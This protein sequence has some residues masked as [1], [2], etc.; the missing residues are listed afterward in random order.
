MASLFA[1]SRAAQWK[2]IDAL[3]EKEQSATATPLVEAIYREARQQ[4]DTPDYVRALLYRLGLLGS[5][6]PEAE[7]QGIALLENDLA[8]ADFPA[9]P[10]LHSLLG[11][12]YTTYLRRYRYRVYQRTAGATP[13]A[14][15][16]GSTL[17]TWG[18]SELGA[19][20]VA[21][22]RQS[23]ADEPARQL[24][25]S[26][27]E[28]GALA[29]AGDK[30]GQILR[31]SLYD[32]LAWRAIQGL[33]NQ[34]L[35]LTQPE[36]Q[37]EFTDPQLFGSAAEFA[38][39]P[40]LAAPD[41][42]LNG[43]LHALQLLQQLTAQRLA[44]TPPQPT[45]L[46]AVDLQRLDYLADLTEG[47]ALADE[48]G[49]ALAR[50]ADLYQTL[51]ISAEFRARRATW[52]HEAGDAVA[53]V[54][55]ARATEAQFPQSRGAQQARQLRLEIEQPE[56][57][58]T[59]ADTV[60]PGQPW[61]LDL[62]LR[63]ITELHAWVYPLELNEWRKLG[64]LYGDERLKFQAKV[65]RRPVAASWA[66]PL[67][68]APLDYQERSVVVAGAALPVGYYL[69]L[70]SN[71]AA[72]PLQE[73]AGLA[74][75]FGPLAVSE[76][77]AVNRSTPA[78]LASWEVLVL[79]RQSGAPLA[80]VQVQAHYKWYDYETSQY[81][82]RQSEVLTTAASGEVLLPPAAEAE[83]L[84]RVHLWRGPDTLL[85]TRLGYYYPPHRPGP[86]EVQ[87]TVLL[88]TDRAIYRP[89]QTLYFKGVLSES[90]ADEA[91]VLPG[92]PVSVRLLDVN[93]QTALTL[94]FTTSSFG[95]FH[96]S[97]VLPTGLLNGQMTLQTDHGSVGFAVEDYKRPT[98]EVTLEPV[99]GQP[100]LGEAVTVSGQARAYAGQPT[101]GATVSYRVTRQALWGGW[102]PWGPRGSS[103]SQQ[104]AHGTTT[105]DAEGRFAITFTPPPAAA[106][107]APRGYQFSLV[108]DVTEAAGETRT[109]TR[110]LFIGANPLSVSLDGPAL[111]DKQHPEEFTLLG[112]NATGE[113]LPAT[114]TVQV[115]ARHY[116]PNPPGVP[117][118]VPKTDDNEAEPELMQTLAFDTQAQP[119]FDLT[120]A[121]A[122][123]PTGRYQLRAVADG[124]DLA[125]DTHDFTLYDSEAT[126]VPYATPD[127][128]LPLARQVAPGEPMALLLGSSEAG[129]NILLEVERG[130]E[131]LRREWLTLAAGEQR[132][133]M[134][135]SGPVRGRGALHVHTTQV[136]DNHLYRHDTTVQ[137]V[138]PP[139]PLVLSLSTFR[140]RLQPGEREIWRLTIRRADGQPAEAELLATLYD[141]SLD[142]FR[143]HGFGAF[144]VAGSYYPA[145][146]EWRGEFGELSSEA[147]FALDYPEVPGVEYPTLT[148][149]LDR[150]SWAT[151]GY[152]IGG[153]TG[154]AMRK[155]AGVQH[156]EIG[157]VHDG[158]ATM[159]WMESA[160]PGG[161]P[162]P[163]AAPAPARERERG[164]APPE[165][166]A[167]PAAA[168]PDLGAV[169]TRSDFREM[170]LW[171]PALRTDEHGDVVLEFQMPEAVT[172]WQLL[173][174]AHDA[175]L[176]S[177]QLTRQLVTQK[178]IQ[179]SPNAPRF[180]RQGDSFTFAAKLSNLTGHATSGTAQLFL[181]DAATGQ[182]VTSELLAGPTRQPVAAG[183]HG[184]VALGWEVRLPADFAAVAVTYRV[185]AQ[186][187]ASPT[188]DNPEPATYSDGEENTLPVLPNRL[189][190]TESL[191]LPVVGA[192][193]RTFELRKLTSTASPTRR[194][195]SL[196]LEMTAN[197]AWYAVQSLT[198]LQEYPYECSEQLFSRLYANLLAAHI[199]Q[200]NPRLKAVLAEWTRQARSGTAQQNALESK[201]AQNQ[202]LKNLLLQETPWVRDAQNETGQLARL[203][204]LFDETR[205]A[206]ET[207]RA[208]LKLQKQQL[209]GGA[210]PWFERMPADRYISQL[211][212]AGFGK[213]HQLGAFNA[214]QDE[215]AGPLL[216]QALR[217]LDQAMA[218]DYDELQ[219]SKDVQLSDNHLGDLQVQALYARSFWP[220]PVAARAEAAY[221]YYRSQAAHYWPGRTRYLQAQLALSLHRADARSTAAQEIMRALAENALHSPE[222][223][224][225]WPDVHAGYYWREAPTETQAT[226]IEAFGEVSGDQH[227]VDE[228]KLWL[229]RQKQT[230]H[231]ES[232]RATTDACYALLLRGADWLAPSQPLHITVGDAPVVPEAAQAGTG[233][234]KTSWPAAEVQPAQGHVA[235]TKADAGV[236]WGALY[237]QYFENL[238]RVTAAATPLS[239]ERE[240]YREAMTAAGP[241]LELL[242]A[243]AP[244]Q[245]GDALV[246]RLVLRTD[247]RLE[248]V[249]L[250]DQRAAGL[251]PIGQTSGYRYQNGLGYYESPRDAATNFF[252]GAVPAGT[253]VFEYRLWASQVG[254]FSGGLSQ[255][256]CLYAP[257]FAAHSAGRRVQIG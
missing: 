127:W 61:P 39:L 99:T 193:T 144:Y 83:R 20:I 123:L 210:F 225:Y 191:P 252:F 231:W 48:Y 107:S 214:A 213:L 82:R 181:L 234:F 69:L 96:G 161:A 55:E 93:G 29:T 68:A 203:S 177:G 31:P 85:L 103:S 222:L 12:L 38:A 190:L 154:G 49:A 64:K 136:R 109:A 206:A 215:V 192:G 223:G 165:P 186:T 114:G 5:Q 174:L 51:P 245:V 240:L 201:L 228:M 115:L 143:R 27:A 54:A 121:L 171:E 140:D 42:H 88:F 166:P 250:K 101:D 106:D 148:T 176:R 50:L 43:Q 254:D 175:R 207:R 157:E 134:L 248:Y 169:P 97:L 253:H 36:Q 89:G 204:T 46:A 35:Y 32:L 53:A 15:A 179:I 131:V 139:Q 87:R 6:T 195:Y 30:E 104:I 77:S 224:M 45:A 90:L 227:A 229:L 135:A 173:A 117:G 235:I 119:N 24:R 72:R 218:D 57:S 56:L 184:S 183:A 125:Q 247:R 17:T 221:A 126:T 187:T 178:E 205:L 216:T 58:L 110:S 237:W 185:V 102:T 151:G 182:D 199:L 156:F 70:V 122:A 158:L 8:T 200:S 211:L 63:N 9:R 124:P 11:E 147:L 238:D 10:I 220:Q 212:V 236:A 37:F 150:F 244:L 44:A 95:S 86:E 160:A 113:P 79:H 28:L 197:P 246:V 84:T 219:Q 105:T 34:E 98:F 198:Y 249:H 142:L 21:H 251:E 149:W 118:P 112:V 209:S 78:E 81:R 239:L 73:R 18:L 111:V 65:V 189:L 208:L 14:N 230:Q 196:T 256:Q 59:A 120:A 71:Q 242:T 241:R 75:S 226:L 74:T 33:R 128:V 2:K 129:A 170:A 159:D 25:T 108:A 137:V 132:R 47:T 152:G 13:T 146:L 168:A 167:P 62:S 180:F 7:E 163:A 145:L 80:G 16:E 67:P 257:E 4:R 155:K 153:G 217:Y 66:L 1:P 60:L 133:L 188:A 40:L 116:R 172:R 23:V 19:A 255:V 52:L 164:L 92:Q 202:D 138:A 41:D 100:R 22:Y 194:N 141:Q 130:G 243:D 76:L 94:T 3:L 91:R 162:R 233:Y 26:L 232:T